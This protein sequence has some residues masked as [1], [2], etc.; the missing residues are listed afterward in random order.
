MIVCALARVR[1]FEMGY[2]DEGEG[3]PLVLLHA[4]PLERSM[5]R[6]QVEALRGVCR[7]ITPD[8]R[9]FGE[10]AG[11]PSSATMEEMALDVAALLDELRI[12]RAVI[13]GLSMG[14]YVTFAFLR[15]FPERV[16]GLILA[17]T[18]P[19]SDDEDGRRTREQN[20]RRAL[21]EGMEPIASGMLPK[22]LAR[23]T[24]ERNPDLVK[25]VRGMLLAAKPQSVAAALRGMA[26]RRDQRDILP[27][28][29]APT[30]I[31]VGSEDTLT[32][33]SDAELMSSRIN[34]ARLKV[35]DGAAHL[36]NLESP[37]EF[38]TALREFLQHL[39][40]PI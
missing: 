6:E 4:F 40:Q 2:E 21:D 27:G 35:L 34:N 11:A 36:S 3:I 20:A 22:L 32:P 7:I 39:H 24:L 5:W 30:L 18:R 29:E 13:G 37:D 9:G 38:N 10:S 31:L 19:Q 16:A 15:L 8:L 26:R 33:P 1:G 14:G 17:D 25:R 28:I 23:T 12:E